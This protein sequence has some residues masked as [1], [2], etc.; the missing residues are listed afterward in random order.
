M[1]TIDSTLLPAVEC[2]PGYASVRWAMLVVPVTRLTTD[3]PTVG[4]W[5]RVI[6]RS[7]SSIKTCC[8]VAGVRAGDSLDFARA[9]RIVIQFESMP[10]DWFNHLAI[11]DPRTL[12]KFLEHGRLQNRGAVPDV[13][14]FLDRQCFISDPRLM[15]A[16]RALLEK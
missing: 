7:R 16:V 6:G 5:S 11:I 4:D 2:N 9:L 8:S 13:A 14:A 1:A 3:V 15:L 12:N 10:C